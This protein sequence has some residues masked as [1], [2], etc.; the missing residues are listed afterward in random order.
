MPKTIINYQNS[1]Y[2]YTNKYNSSYGFPGTNGYLVIETIVTGSQFSALVINGNETIAGN[3]QVNGNETVTGNLQVNGNIGVTGTV[4]ATDLI[5]T[6]DIRLKE[7][8]QNIDSALEK[9]L[10]MHGV[11][12]TRKNEQGRKVGV[13]AQEVEEVLPE[14]VYSDEVGMKSVSYGSIVGLLIEAIKEQNEQI[15][16]LQI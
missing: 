8:I 5:A 7:N 6:S 16:K 11:Y 1:S 13:I 2:P 10:R 3:L 15:K 12:Y 9:V 4:S 14:V